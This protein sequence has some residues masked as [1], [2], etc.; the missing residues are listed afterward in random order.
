MLSQDSH[1]KPEPSAESRAWG[2]LSGP[3]GR[4][5]SAPA[6]PS[7]AALWA[8]Q[9]CH[10]LSA[11]SESSRSC[12]L[13]T[14]SRFQ[15]LLLLQLP[16]VLGQSFKP[17]TDPHRC[18]AVEPPGVVP[19]LLGNELYA[20]QDLGDVVNVPFLYLQHLGC[21]GIWLSLSTCCLSSGCHI[22]MPQAEGLKQ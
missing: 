18:M 12:G 16:E 8:A 14:W 3:T 2:S 7:T 22:Q 6:R 5:P 10:W 20:L 17:A 11:S 15:W 9:G 13:Q 4:V 1:P 19:G 21:P